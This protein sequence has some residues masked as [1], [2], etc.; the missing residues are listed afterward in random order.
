MAQIAIIPE[1]KVV[2]KLFDSESGFNV[3]MIIPNI[4]PINK[5]KYEFSFFKD[6]CFINLFK[7]K[8]DEKITKPKNNEKICMGKCWKS[9]EINE[10]NNTIETIIPNTKGS[11]NSR[12]VNL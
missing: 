10:T 12:L 1:K 8:I 9:C 6:F 2:I 11:K 5:Y 7:I 3:E 4:I